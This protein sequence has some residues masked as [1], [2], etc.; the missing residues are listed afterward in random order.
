MPTCR[1]QYLPINKQCQQEKIIWKIES[2]VCVVF[3]LFFLLRG[4]IAERSDYLVY[5]PCVSIKNDG[6]FDT[7]ITCG[8]LRTY[9]VCGGMSVV[10]VKG[11]FVTVTLNTHHLTMT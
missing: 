7:D 11:L 4:K 6:R 9:V 8:F 5:G 1:K 3:L 10:I 2:S